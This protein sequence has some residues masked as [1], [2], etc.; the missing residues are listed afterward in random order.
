MKKLY[1]SDKSKGTTDYSFVETE[2]GERIGRCSMYKYHNRYELWNVRIFPGFKQQGYGTKML[3][4][5]IRRYKRFIK[6]KPLILYVYKTN[7]VAIHLYESL[8]FK[9]TKDAEENIYE[10]QLCL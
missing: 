3:K 2:T 9:I 5:I 6:D 8:G 10:M 7:N 4:E 1:V